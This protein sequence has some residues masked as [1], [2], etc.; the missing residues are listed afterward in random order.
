M[1]RQGPP[2]EARREG[3]RAKCVSSVSWEVSRACYEGSRSQ[4]DPQLQQERV[5]VLPDLP[6]V[7][8]VRGLQHRVG[9][10]PVVQPQRPALLAVAA[11][12]AQRRAHQIIA[13]A[14]LEV[15]E[16]AVGQQ[17]RAVAEL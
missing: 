8:L 10:D 3:R 2:P 6:V 17:G 9:R 13:D 4:P 7:E 15:L 5:L 12:G 16:D 14:E 1:P 11:G